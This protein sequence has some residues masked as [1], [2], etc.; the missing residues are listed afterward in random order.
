[1]CQE[2]RPRDTFVDAAILQEE[3]DKYNASYDAGVDSDWH[4]RDVLLTPIRTAPF[5]AIKFG[6]SI[7]TVPNGV[8]VDE[9]MRVLDK[10][11]EPIPGLYASGN[12]SGGRYGVDYPVVM[13][14]NSHGSALTFGFLV[15]EQLAQ[16]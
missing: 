2:I 3:I 1:M 10:D 8:E 14:G 6:P 16:S 5:Y 13:N 12:A 15:G 4:K 7:L 9:M 11:L